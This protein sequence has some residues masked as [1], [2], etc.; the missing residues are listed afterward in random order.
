MSGPLHWSVPCSQGSNADM[1]IASAC[2]ASRV[3]LQ[4][5]SGETRDI[6]LAQ[7]LPSSSR[8]SNCISLVVMSDCYCTV[9]RTVIMIKTCWVV[10]C[11]TTLICSTPLTP[12]PS[13]TSTTQLATQGP[14]LWWMRKTPCCL[15]RPSPGTMTWKVQLHLRTDTSVDSNTS[16]M[17]RG[18]T[19]I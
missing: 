6:H 9:N 15:T 18:S 13:A 16:P 3:Q 12:T 2:A 8:G 19:Y 1:F 4:A 5:W 17:F 10:L 7:H 14:S 11:S